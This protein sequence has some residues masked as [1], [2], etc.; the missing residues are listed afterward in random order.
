MTT[1]DTVIIGGGPA[2]LSAG[3]YA[4][5]AGLQ[6]IL[7]EKIFLGGQAV[8]TGTIE[9]YPG[10]P[11]AISGFEIIGRMEEQVRKHNLPI[12]IKEVKSLI[13]Q[14]DADGYTLHLGDGQILNART[15]ILAT[16]ALA[17]NLDVPG[18]KE[19]TGRGV[20][21]CATCDGPL[22]REKE[23]MVIG[24]G[25][26]ALEEAIFL[27]R[28][29]RKV[30]IVHRRDEFRGDKIL[31]DRLLQNPKIHVIWNSVVKEIKGDSVVREVVLYNR[32]N[33]SS[34]SHKID[35]LFI[36]IGTRPNT[37]WLNSLVTL[38]AKGF[39]IT[40]EKLHTNLPGLFAAG[41]CRQKELRQIVTAAGDGAIA[42]MMAY[43]Y[44][45]E[46]A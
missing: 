6:A 20:S 29:G 17:L 9:N 35:G 15:V 2:G 13:H 37:A 1:Y 38:D 30:S 19:F 36:Y 3:L 40:D 25:N 45:Q 27:A 28:F 41:D 7:L 5:R 24:G 26:S 42:G 21:Y 39:I 12:E 32:V 16:G 11:E 22:F 14:K 34:N 46:K 4:A 23:I 10:F 43:H 18:E 44:L 31:Q 33:Q 8:T